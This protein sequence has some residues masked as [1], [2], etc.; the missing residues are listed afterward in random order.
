M[1]YGIH[2]SQELVRIFSEK[3]YQGADPAEAK[4]LIIGNDANYSPEISRHPFFRHIIDYHKDGVAFW[5]KTGTHHPFLLGDYPF[6]RRKGGVRYHLNFSKLGFGRTDAK[7][8]SFVELLNVPTIGNT[9]SDKELFFRLMNRGH[10][11]WLESMILR[12]DRK[13]VL[14]N[15]TLARSIH[16]I[17][18]RFGVMRDLAH[19]VVGKSP[20][21]VVLDTSHVVLYNG[22]SFSHSLSNEY[23]RDLVDLMRKFIR[24]EGDDD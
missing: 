9:G 5:Q 24:E 12:E 7:N 1:K 22:Y 11:M 13:F 14:I 4:V 8:F 17:S 20:P 2:P 16:V 19:A 23:L 3:P 10:L 18:K 6:D 21:A 15:Q